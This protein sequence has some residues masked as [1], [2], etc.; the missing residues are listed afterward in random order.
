M[1]NDGMEQLWLTML[2]IEGTCVCVCV[3]VQTSQL[4]DSTERHCAAVS[5]C[6]WRGLEQDNARLHGASFSSSSDTVG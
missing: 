6:H 5:Y 3:C 4:P 2:D 1:G